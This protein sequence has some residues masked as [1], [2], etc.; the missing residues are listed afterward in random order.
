MAKKKPSFPVALM[1]IV[2]DRGW[3]ATIADF[4]QILEPTDKVGELR[5]H[6]LAQDLQP[7]MQVFILALIKKAKRNLR[8]KDRKPVTKEEF[9]KISIQMSIG[10]ADKVVSAVVA[11]FGD[12][13]ALGSLKKKLLKDG[14]TSRLS[15]LFQDVISAEV[16]HVLLL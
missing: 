16:D 10:L 1:G 13:A 3:D 4:E 7:D 14:A 11:Y 6:V 5:A 15:G 9:M 2:A 8:V 12:P